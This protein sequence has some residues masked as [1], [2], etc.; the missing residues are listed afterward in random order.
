MAEKWS[1]IV[2]GTSVART[3]SAL[4]YTFPLIGLIRA[5]SSSG[6]RLLQAEKEERKKGF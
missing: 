1:D 5:W 2:D 3:G 6:I 4:V